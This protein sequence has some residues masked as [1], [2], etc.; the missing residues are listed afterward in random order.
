MHKF[1]LLL[2]PI[3][4]VG[5]QIAP[6]KP[7]PTLA[8]PL[9]DNAPP[10]VDASTQTDIDVKNS[11]TDTKQIAEPIR[12]A[13]YGKLAVNTQMPLSALYEWGQN[14]DVG[15][16]S[17]SLP[18]GATAQLDFNANGAVLQ[19]T[20]G[21][22]SA[23]SVRTLFQKL[24]RIDAPIE[25]LPYWIMGQ[26]QGEAVWDTQGRLLQDTIAGWQANFEY[27]KGKYPSR[28]VVRQGNTSLNISINH[29]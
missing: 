4:L 12:F 2:I 14:G 20:F 18:F 13:I 11:S 8:I 3:W 1:V 5:C 23:Q 24:T 19:S 29:L 6:Q 9:N 17:L 10:S 16:I 15:K 26:A 28:I 27:E 22:T 25:V 21:T 7:S